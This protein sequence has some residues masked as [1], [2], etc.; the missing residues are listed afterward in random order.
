MDYHTLTQAGTAVSEAEKAT[1]F[2]IQSPAFLGTPQGPGC[3]DAG[4]EP[5]LL[6]LLWVPPHSPSPDPSPL[7]W[8][9][10]V[11]PRKLEGHSVFQ[12]QASSWGQP[13]EPGRGQAHPIPGN[14]PACLFHAQKPTYPFGA[15]LFF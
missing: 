11:S 14:R 12:P 9:L 3:G 15:D 8:K 4:G 1:S 5:R 2:Q 6:A 7:P 10:E 13:R